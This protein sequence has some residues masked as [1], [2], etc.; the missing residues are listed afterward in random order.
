[1]KGSYIIYVEV[2]HDRSIRIGSLGSVSF[3]KGFYAYVGS[4][5]NGLSGRI[6][7]HLRKDKKLHWHIDYLLRKARI[8][9]VHIRPSGKKEE[10]ALAQKF[11]SR[12]TGI[13]GFGCSDCKCASHLFYSK[14]LD[15]LRNRVQ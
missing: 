2:T 7:R 13:V 12:F 8:R 6:M 14:S 11:A 9:A 15:D 10:C 3:K 1:M 5:M 4:A